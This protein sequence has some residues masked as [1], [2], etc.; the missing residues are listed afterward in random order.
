MIFLKRSLLELDWG[1][2]IITLLHL[3][4]ITY[5][6]LFSRLYKYTCT[7]ILYTVNFSPQYWVSRTKIYLPRPGVTISCDLGI[8]EFSTLSCFTQEPSMV[9]KQ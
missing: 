8:G 2:I 1:G 9:E 5:S 4:I 7:V 6:S 3:I